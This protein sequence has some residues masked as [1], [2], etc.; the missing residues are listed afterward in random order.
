M[1]P[2]VTSCGSWIDDETVGVGSTHAQHHHFVCDPLLTAE[3]VIP[4]VDLFVHDGRLTRSAGAF[5]A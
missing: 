2:V 1:T 4:M 3:H 5:M